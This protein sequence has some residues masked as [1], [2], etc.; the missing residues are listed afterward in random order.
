[1]FVNPALLSKTLLR[2]VH[3][4]FFTC[5]RLRL[6]KDLLVFDVPH[7]WSSG[8]LTRATNT[9][10][11]F[12]SVL[13][14]LLSWQQHECSPP[15]KTHHCTPWLTDPKHRFPLR[16]QHFTHWWPYEESRSLT[17]V[18]WHLSWEIKSWKVLKLEYNSMGRLKLSA[19]TSIVNLLVLWEFCTMCSDLIHLLPNCSRSAYPSLPTQLCPFICCSYTS[20]QVQFL[21][22]PILEC[23]ATHWNLAYQGL[24]FSKKQ[25]PDLPN[26]SS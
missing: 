3:W 25:K 13:W 20:P 7:L 18:R 19:S 12:P 1:M 10:P 6:E 14:A 9:I 16:T 11:L 2:N 8:F 26:P 5:W 22:S 24:Y 4:W 15:P 17:V 23:V 21:L